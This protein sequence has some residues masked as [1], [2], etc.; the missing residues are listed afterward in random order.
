MNSLV[1][2]LQD[3]M[4]NERQRI[5]AEKIAKALT[6]TTSAMQRLTGAVFRLEEILKITEREE[7]RTTTGIRSGKTDGK[8]ARKR[9]AKEMGGETMGDG[10][11]C[12]GKAEKT[13]RETEWEGMKPISTIRVGEQ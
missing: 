7:R 12:Q 5:K 1:S 6:E 9:G 11:N 10:Q 4:E 8:K 2:V 3:L 13:G